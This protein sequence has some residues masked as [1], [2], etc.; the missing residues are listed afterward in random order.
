MT[1]WALSWWLKILFSLGQYSIFSF[2][3]IS[4]NTSTDCLTEN[5]SLASFS[6]TKWNNSLW[7]PG[8]HLNLD[9]FLLRVDIWGSCL[10]VKWFFL[11]V[12][13]PLVD[14]DLII[15]ASQ[16]SSFE[17]DL[18]LG[19]IFIILDIICELKPFPLRYSSTIL[20][21]L[22]SYDFK[23]S[24]P[25]WKKYVIKIY[26]KNIIPSSTGENFLSFLGT[27]KRYS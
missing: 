22:C 10:S 1:T 9:N 13:Y 15:T 4:S 27:S 6:F 7:I 12:S 16:M 11:M 24:V 19:D 21:F 18:F 20:F 3:D 17:Y 26:S 25:M 5:L 2:K 8:A 23:S 14:I